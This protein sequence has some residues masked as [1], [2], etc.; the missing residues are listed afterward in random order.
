MSGKLPTLHFYLSFTDFLVKCFLPTFH[1]MAVQKN[2]LTF[3]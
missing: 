1:E 2:D 3:C